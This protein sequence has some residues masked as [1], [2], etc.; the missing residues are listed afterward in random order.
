MMKARCMGRPV[1]SS[2]RETFDSVRRLLVIVVNGAMMRF[3]KGGGREGSATPRIKAYEVW[4][5][6]VGN[7]LIGLGQT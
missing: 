3:Q 1:A 2:S 4:N 6:G 5:R 7:P